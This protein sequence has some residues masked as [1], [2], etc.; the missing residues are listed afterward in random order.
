M[1]N[2]R[3]LGRAGPANRYVSVAAYAAAAGVSEAT[4]RRWYR[5]GKVQGSRRTAH[6]HI[7]IY[8]SEYEKLERVTP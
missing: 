1:V 5:E 7:R 8:R 3:S 6:G 2:V 4:V